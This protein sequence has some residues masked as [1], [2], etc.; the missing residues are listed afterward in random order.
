MQNQRKEKERLEHLERMRR[1][2]F[3]EI[4]NEKMNKR[5]LFIYVNG[6]FEPLPEKLKRVLYKDYIKYTPLPI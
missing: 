6:V 4:E 2:K 1:W 3:E 5:D